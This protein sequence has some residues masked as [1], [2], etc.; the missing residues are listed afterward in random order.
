M[1]EGVRTVSKTRERNIRLYGILQAIRAHPESDDLREQWAYAAIDL[2][3]AV[4]IVQ[5]ASLR[6]SP[7]REDLEQ[8]AVL[9]FHKAALKLASLT[10][11]FSPDNL[12]RILYSV[13]KFSMLKELARLKR[14]LP[15]DLATDMDTLRSFSSMKAVRVENL[16][17]ED[18]KNHP[19]QV[20]PDVL[21]EDASRDKYLQTHLPQQF[22]SQVDQQNLYAATP[23]GAAVR[24]CTLQRLRG[25]YVSKSFVQAYWTPPNSALVV[26]YSEYL[27]RAVVLAAALFHG[28]V[29]QV[30]FR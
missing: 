7:D 14:H 12:F 28:R 8:S 26:S 30:S 11:S 18:D 9:E 29:R 19:V 16:P 27:A 25:R 20:G 5:F 17:D 22:L 13:A 1:E 24:F 4:F 2:T 21:L 6:H 23:W 15:Q 10:E 3:R